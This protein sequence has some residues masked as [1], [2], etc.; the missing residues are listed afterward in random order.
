VAAP[1]TLVD[2]LGARS[3]QWVGDGWLSDPRGIAVA[4]DGRVAVADPVLDRVHL[5]SPDGQML[6]LGI[7]ENLD[8]PDGVA[9]APGGILV[10]ADT[11]S[12]RVLL[13]RP[14]D[15]ETVVMP[16]PDGGWFG[17]RSAA[18]AGDGTIAVADTGNKRIVLYEPGE[19]SD[20]TV[21]TIGTAGSGPGEFSEPVGLAWIDEARLVVCDTGNHRLQIL[22][23]SGHPEAV[24]ELGG[25]WADFYARPQIAVMPDGRFLVSDTPDAAL[26]LV[27]TEQARRIE[28]GGEGITPTGLAIA[29]NTLYLADSAGRIWVLELS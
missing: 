18:V 6:E 8:R 23:R 16:E 9:W 3:A 19:G 12:H 4:A 25:I 21:R 26:W 17:P 5:L 1:V 14:G 2:E 10:V 13:H 7:A 20:F 28:L 27:D 22:H 29:S 11:W 24:V 15:D